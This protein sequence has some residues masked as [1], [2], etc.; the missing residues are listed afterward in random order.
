M[1]HVCDVLAEAARDMLSGWRYI[2]EVHGD[3]SGVGW[4]R[5][6]GKVVAAL[7]E[8]YLIKAKEYK[9]VGYDQSK[10]HEETDDSL[11]HPPP[12]SS[13]KIQVRLHYA[14]PAKPSPGL[15][16]EWKGHGEQ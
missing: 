15:L 9:K 11:P 2:R 13:R 16:E 7:A 10:T 1:S 6:E 8:Y 3:L 5:A 12:L 14:G 4:D